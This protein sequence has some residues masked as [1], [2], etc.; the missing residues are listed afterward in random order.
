MR[1][2]SKRN[3]K[4]EGEGE[5][6]L[7]KEGIWQAA[8]A[9]VAVFLLAWL[10]VKFL[11]PV[12]L[13]FLVGLGAACLAEPGV[14][15]LE[16]RAGLPRPLAT[17][18]GVSLLLGLLGLAL[19]GLG[20]AAYREL[21]HLAAS[22]PVL[23]E[24]AAQPVGRIRQWLLEQAERA[25]EGL[26][27]SFRSA[28]DSAFSGGDALA[29]KATGR[30]LGL[31]SGV[32]AGLPD[33]FLFIGTGVLASF[34]ISANLPKLRPWLRRRMPEKWMR[35]LRPMIVNLR[36]SV[37][38]WLKAQAKL[39]G[40]TFCIVTAGLCLLRTEAPLL[41]GALIALVDALPMLGTGTVLVPWGILC[42]LQGKPGTGLGLI[43]LYGVSAMAR[44][45][46]EPRLVGSQMGLHPLLTLVCIYVGYRL[47][48]VLGMLLAPM[49]VITAQE[50]AQ[51][52]Q[53]G[54]TGES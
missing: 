7:K 48:G 23:L 9:L 39:M 15:L 32:I 45:A 41:A 35:R 2:K 42:F 16:R 29:A 8:L 54:R 27:L 25:P 47:W 24:Q 44:A 12:T 49:L 17:G 34:M 3:R 46:L 22:L 20:K 13:P 6:V 43:V 10:S 36:T 30:V 18:I 1:E 40:M 28:I 31:A 38:G 51:L 50:L 11:L 14:R 52:L 5:K 37:S 21:D 26:R 19:Y 33:W 53:P 4:A